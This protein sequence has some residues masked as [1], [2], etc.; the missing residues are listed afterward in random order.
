M[1]AA[2]LN[3]EPDVDPR[4]VR[5]GEQLLCHGQAIRVVGAAEQG[6]RDMLLLHG[7]YQ[8]FAVLL[9][10]RNPWALQNQRIAAGGRKQHRAQQYI[11]SGGKPAAD[12]FLIARVL[13]AFDCLC[14]RQIGSP[15]IAPAIG[16]ISVRFGALDCFQL[17]PAAFFKDGRPVLPGC[18]GVLG[19]AVNG[20]KQIA[21]C[22]F[23]PGK[24]RL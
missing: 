13:H 18:P 22:L 3:A 2:L 1:P 5:C 21:A 17:P 9:Q 16:A 14:R 23:L 7:G 4:L 6:Q 24:H 12:D 15:V 10:Q 8:T 19:V 11:A 20:Q